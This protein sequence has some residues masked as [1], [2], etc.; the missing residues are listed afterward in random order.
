MVQIQPRKLVLDRA[1]FIAPTRQ[2]ELDQIR[3]LSCLK[4]LAHK[5]EFGDLS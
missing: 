2:H 1:G 4:Y 3:R 5:V